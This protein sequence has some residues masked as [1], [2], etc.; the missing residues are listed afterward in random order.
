MDRFTG[1]KIPDRISIK[2]SS[3]VKLEFRVLILIWIWG[4]KMK[5]KSEIKLANSPSLPS[6]VFLLL[7]GAEANSNSTFFKMPLLH[8]ASGYSTTRQGK[9]GERSQLLAK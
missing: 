1:R 9:W 4:L 7:L 5:I 3:R 2:P 6:N 8:D